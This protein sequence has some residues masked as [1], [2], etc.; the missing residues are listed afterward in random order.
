MPEPANE[1][2]EDTACCFWQAVS[3]LD[4]AGQ[5]YPIKILRQEDF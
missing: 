1:V 2:G 5:Q 3:P 4:G